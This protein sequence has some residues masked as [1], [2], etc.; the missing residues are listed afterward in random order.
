MS[1]NDETE[2]ALEPVQIADKFAPLP[3]G[4]RWRAV[5]DF[6]PGLAVQ[7]KGR[8]FWHEVWHFAIG[9][10]SE[11]GIR[12]CAADVL[13]HIAVRSKQ[14]RSVLA[15]VAKRTRDE[16][17]YAHRQVAKA[18]RARM[19]AAELRAIL[20]DAGVDGETAERLS[21]RIERW[22]RSI[23]RMESPRW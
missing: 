1:E 15:E 23:A 7:R 18:K 5:E 6:G 19:T 3:E 2:P 20:T 11:Q 14:Q 8:W 13:N 10:W 22:V 17:T 12:T 16:T 9:D 4:Y 21:P